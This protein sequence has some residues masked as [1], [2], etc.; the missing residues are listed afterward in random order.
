MDALV[1]TVRS[2]HFEL[3]DTFRRSQAKALDICGLGPSECDYR[4]VSSGP[5][6]R[7]RAYGGPKAVPSL[8]IVSAPIKRPY[9]WDLSPSVSRIRSCLQHGLRVYLLEWLAPSRSA[10][11]AGLDEYTSAIQAGAAIVSKDARGACPIL[12]GHSLGGTLAAIFCALEPEAARGLVLLSAPL[13]FEKASSRFR[14][15]LVRL[16]PSS[17]SETDIVAGSLLSQVSAAASPDTFLWSRGLDAALSLTDPATLDIHWRIERWALDEMALPGRLVHQIVSWLY[18][19]DRFHKATLAVGGKRV[20]PSTLRTPTLAFINSADEVSPP[21]AVLP[22]LAAM[23]TKV[24]CLVDPLDEL[25]VGLP[26]LAI[27]AGRQA[28]AR[29]WPDIVSWIKTRR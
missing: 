28:K 1:D 9:I 15:A 27:L 3:S 7:L 25:G 21:A 23:P 26:H 2:V 20:G 24:K 13:S 18:S 29:I 5:H 16:A 22:F 14:D 11:G 6:W 12:M 8:L 17:F 4:V 19:E 10:G